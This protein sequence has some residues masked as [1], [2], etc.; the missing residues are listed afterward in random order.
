MDD[1]P[2][3][4]EG[5]KAA[6]NEAAEHSSI[7][8]R[9]PSFAPA[10]Q[11]SLHVAPTS[12][13]PPRQPVERLASLNIHHRRT[14]RP[15]VESSSP[16]TP[17]QFKKSKIQPKSAIRRSKEERE[18]AERAEAERLQARLA[19]SSSSSNA[20][21]NRG[22][23]QSRGGAGD[24]RGGFS[25]RWQ[26]E[27]YAGAGAA[28][29]LGGATPAEDKRQKELIP[30]SRGGGRSSLLSGVSREAADTESHA[31]VKKEA[32]A[33]KGKAKD[34]DGDTVMRG[35]SSGKRQSARV[36]Q[37]K[38]GLVDESSED[39]LLELD[40][41]G[42]KIDIEHINLIS[43]DDLS[44]RA[45]NGKGK[46]RERTPRLPSSA[47]MRP[48]RIDRHE[49]EERTISVNT[50]AS[51]LTSERLRKRARA[52]HQA[53][54]SLF[55]EGTPDP[56]SG[57]PTRA[58]GKTKARDIE[59]IKNER[60]WQGVYRDEEDEDTA[61]EVKEEPKEHGDAMVMDDEPQS[62]Q[63][64]AQDT[65]AQDNSTQPDSGTAP[66]DSR[67]SPSADP[68]TVRRPKS[69]GK[70][71]LIRRKPVLQTEEDHQEWQRYQD[72]VHLIRD[73]LRMPTHQGQP[74]D[75]D[76]NADGDAKTPDADQAK[77]IDRKQ[78]TVYLF[79]LPPI[80]PDIKDPH[81][82]QEGKIK[83]KPAQPKSDTE[84]Q[85]PATSTTAA[86]T[87]D[88]GKKPQP[89]AGT[90]APDTIPIKPE[91]S[92]TIS[93]LPSS[94]PTPRSTHALPPNPTDRLPPGR[95]GHITLD[96]T[97]FPSATWTPSF[98]LDFGRASDYGAFQEVVLLKSETVELP[99]RKEGKGVKREGSGIKQ[100]DGNV[101]EEGMGVVGGRAW[102]VGQVGGGFV[103]GPDW[104]WMFGR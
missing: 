88:K 71:A 58:K 53:Q 2:M 39:E 26:S 94:T 46:E 35:T 90:K 40:Q 61:V 45:D 21:P 14:S 76:I 7:D 79:Q 64:I 1:H 15:S 84:T 54:G 93:T 8:Q 12:T 73:H 98:H 81:K 62:S 42:R 22:V 33:K 13:C 97:G 99:P 85:E 55:L 50:E 10:N 4:N 36:M 24:A 52:K 92:T 65:P 28:G 5:R 70:N 38:A 63:T 32:G 37:E 69:C 66:V 102:A 6:G 59:F 29:F 56:S 30:R 101:K 67:Q 95:L 31:K 60:K 44:D 57:R 3:D 103:M 41:P 100:E 47:F 89:Q 27:R 11:P 74:E 75:L 80:L 104:G 49:H 16:G 9:L 87:K 77:L 72:D 82:L 68:Q 96:H 83:R 23:L 91:P 25:S 20:T 86:A 51:S 17:E 43:D 48:I 78:N 18:A 34:T 19:A